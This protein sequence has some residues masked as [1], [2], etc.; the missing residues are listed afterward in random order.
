MT[1]QRPWVLADQPPISRVEEFPEL[2]AVI[3]RLLWQRGYRTAAAIKQFLRPEY[4]QDLQDPFV[5]TQMRAAVDQIIAAVTAQRRITVYGDYDVD[6]VTATATMVEVLRAL[7]ANV[8]W[9]LPERLA[10]GYGLNVGAIEELA[11]KGTQLLITVDCGSTNVAEIA[12]AN[13]LGIPVVVLDHHHQP[14]QIPQAAAIIN[15]V[16]ERETRSFQHYSSGGVAFAV[17]CAL[18]Q[19]TNNGATL[20][21]RV[22]DGWEKWLM[23]LTALST[24]ADMMPLIG[25]NRLLVKYGLVVLRKTRRP[26]LRA[27]F[28][29]MGSEIETADETTI[30]FQIAPRLNAA[31]RLQHASIALELLLTRDAAQGRQLAEQLQ[32]INAERQHLTEMAVDEALEQIEQ[33][34]EQSAYT[35]FAPHWSPG[36]IGLI[37]GRLVERVWRP[38]LVMTQNGEEIVGSGRSTP[39]YDIMSALDAGAEHF[40]RFGG[41]PGAC[42][43]TL[44]TLDQRPTFERWFQAH[45]SETVPTD[46][47]LKPVQLDL[48]TT[49][50][51]LDPTTIDM[52]D[53]CA[54]YGQQNPRPVFLLSNVTIR[55]AQTVG[56]KRQ[57][58]KVVVGQGEQFGKCI[59]FRLG[60]RV[61]ELVP[62]SQ[63][64]L[65]VEVS[66]NI[67]N[68]RK[69]RQ[70]KI[71]DWRKAS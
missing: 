7:G 66:W 62:G 11:A 46:R 41:H 17:A 55:E 5:F 54:P 27:L 45:A 15:P 37:A 60:D 58:V 32:S 8:N 47:T 38:V 29:V 18:L 12:R 26:G 42:G 50:K 44:I 34:G 23:D 69:E 43:F 21:H 52:I 6:G 40:R 49:L 14:A 63:A 56:A 33:Q 3:V 57:H 16:F 51:E 61:A 19:A 2:P 65:A 24:V 13:E 35:A 31:G 71:I 64:D 53:V 1:N 28:D 4:E 36:I 22:P 68:G 30:G 59:G 20:N 9:Y 25:E 48:S 39:G 67:W 70:L 10:E